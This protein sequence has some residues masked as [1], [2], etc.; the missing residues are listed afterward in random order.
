MTLLMYLESSLTD[1]FHCNALCPIFTIF[2]A[3]AAS[4][5]RVA[6]DLPGCTVIR[7][8]CTVTLTLYGWPSAR[9][10]AR[11]SGCFAIEL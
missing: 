1:I 7:W 2:N 4:C 5:A 3:H 6:M 11:R 10:T 9:C 8:L